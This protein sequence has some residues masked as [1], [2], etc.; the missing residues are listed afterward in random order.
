MYNWPK[1]WR[2]SNQSYSS[3]LIQL[4]P[5]HTCI[6]SL[7]NKI[8]YIKKKNI[9]WCK[10]VRMF[11]NGPLSTRVK[12]VWFKIKGTDIR[13]EFFV[14]LIFCFFSRPSEKGSVLLSSFAFVLNVFLS[15]ARSHSRLHW[16]SQPHEL[17]W[18]TLIS[19]A[20]L[21]KNRHC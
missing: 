1:L 19:S 15:A 11:E 18:W 13:S 16:L 12:W 4:L 8:C 9:I 20:Q 6:P 7:G 3:I 10:S 21:D 5:Q 14:Y 17:F 2:M